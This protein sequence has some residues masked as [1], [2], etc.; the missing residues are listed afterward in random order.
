MS[1]KR[2]SFTPEY[3]EQVA[4]MVVEEGVSG[5]SRGLLRQRVS[6][7]AKFELI[8]AEKHTLN[9]NGERKYRVTNMCS[10]LA[11]SSS[12]YYERRSRPESATAQRRERL[13]E[14]IIDIFD[15][16]DETY[17]H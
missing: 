1:N 15:D 5:K 4:R 10:W 9:A 12:G 14:L 16:S 8:D 11:V 7:S 3:K 2:R 17:D 13:K 6:V